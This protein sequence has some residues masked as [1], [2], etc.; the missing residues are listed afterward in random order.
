VIA[1][2]ITQSAPEL[3]HSLTLLEPP[4]PFLIPTSPEFAGALERAAKLYF[5]GDKTGAMKKFAVAVVGD[6]APRE[7]LAQFDAEYLERWLE[8]ADPL[9]QSDIPALQRWSFAEDDLAAIEPPVLNICGE[10]TP[11]FF[12]HVYLT[13]QKRLPHCKSL[14][15]P[16]ASHALLQMAPAEV[17][18][19]IAEFVRG[20]PFQEHHSS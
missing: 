1:L 20:R 15:V 19:H 10:N 8:D 16:G 13:V 12:G 5:G 9:F 14:I 2:Q 11:P 18:Q 6:T 7:V 17:A 4:L 3:V